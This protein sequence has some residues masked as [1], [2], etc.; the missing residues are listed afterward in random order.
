MNGIRPIIIEQ[1]FSGIA[2]KITTAPNHEVRMGQ[3][4]R[5]TQTRQ[6]HTQHKLVNSR[7]AVCAAHMTFWNMTT[8]QSVLYF[9]WRPSLWSTQAEEGTRPFGPLKP[10]GT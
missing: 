2:K 7:L 6:C 5:P 8:S 4:P 9:F 1:H 3:K 10:S